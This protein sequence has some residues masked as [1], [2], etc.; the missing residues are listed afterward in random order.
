MAENPLQCPPR[1]AKI[2]CIEGNTLAT[3]RSPR[4]GPSVL[5]TRGDFSMNRRVRKINTASLAH[6]DR[7]A[8]QVKKAISLAITEESIDEVLSDDIRYYIAY[9]SEVAFQKWYF[10]TVSNPKRFLEKRQFFSEFKSKY[11]LQGIDGEYLDR[12]WQARARILELIKKDDLDMLFHDYFFQARTL[13]N[14]YTTQNVFFT[15]LVHTFRP[16]DYCVLD[17]KVSGYFDLEK[18]DFLVA[19]YAVSKAYREWANE[20]RTLIERLRQV[21]K[22]IDKDGIFKDSMTDLKL[23]DL[24]FLREGRKKEQERRKRADKITSNPTARSRFIF[25]GQGESQVVKFDHSNQEYLQWLRTHP[26]GYVM[27]IWRH[28]APAPERYDPIVHT[29][30]CGY[31]G[32]S[33]RNPTEG[34]TIKFWSNNWHDLKDPDGRTPRACQKCNPTR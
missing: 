10:E 30:T 31:I 22:R 9:P 29:A 14:W 3:C 28:P 17:S 18:E 8:N 2:T 12:L 5:T 11:T 21:L 33:N 34:S 24:V 4:V 15:K 7:L 23:L 1:C 27:S 13:P 19:F 25:A 20:N 16:A 26:H 6:R 32:R